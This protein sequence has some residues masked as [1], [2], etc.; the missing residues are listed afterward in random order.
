MVEDCKNGLFIKMKDTDSI[1][2]VLTNLNN[3]REMLSRLGNEARATI[4]QNFNPHK[5]I[6]N[7]N[8]IYGMA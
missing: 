7:L 6:Q 8:V 1:I 4:F 3:D 5:Y 2:E